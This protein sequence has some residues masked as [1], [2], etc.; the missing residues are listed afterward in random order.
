MEIIK[1]KN[2]RYSYDFYLKEDDKEL[3]I[4]FGGN[5]DLYWSL[6]KKNIN[7]KQIKP[8][9]L[10]KEC[11]KELKETFT[12][13]KENYYI[14]TLFEN[15]YN[16]IKECKLYTEDSYFDETIS[17]KDRNKE[18][19][20]TEKYKYLFDGKIIKWHSDEED[21]LIA[22]RVSIEKIDDTYVL[23]FTRPEL[24]EDKFSF[25]IIGNI[26]I[27]FRNSGSRYDPFNIIFMRMFNKLQEYNPEYHQIHLEELSYQKKLTLKQ[28]RK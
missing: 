13:T 15:L 7:L 12:I 26:S 19:Q 25:R 3:R 14:Y 16:D 9:E 8:S 23:K 24:T 1:I 21:Y 27:R 28:N 18:Y 17:Y 6:T 2:N 4:S 5:L 20:N 22:D 10:Y 11:K